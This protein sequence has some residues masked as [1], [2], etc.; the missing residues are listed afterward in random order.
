MPGP[1]LASGDKYVNARVA[2]GVGARVRTS[3]APGTGVNVVIA[4]VAVG[5]A[6]A[7]VGDALKSAGRPQARLPHAAM[8]T[9]R[10]RTPPKAIL[11]RWESLAQFKLLTCLQNHFTP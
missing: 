7:T 3:S 2:V 10:T 1:I 11:A 9:I 5:R 6:A 4:A 8:T